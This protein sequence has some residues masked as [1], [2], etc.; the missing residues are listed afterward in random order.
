MAVACPGSAVRSPIDSGHLEQSAV[1]ECFGV[2]MESTNEKY[3]WF[4]LQVKSRREH[5]VCSHL[6]AKGYE[7]FLPQYKCKRRWSDRIKEVVLPLFAGYVFCRFDPENRLPIMVVPGVIVIVGAA[8]K[9]TPVDDSEI[10]V[11]Q[12]IAKSGLPCQPWPFLRV[13][14]RV[15][16]DYGALQGIEGILSSFKSQQRIVVSV[17]LLQRSVALEVD[18][19]W[20]SPVSRQHDVRTNSLFCN[21]RSTPVSPRLGY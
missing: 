16:V 15:R 2:S 7:C 3:P 18:R 1:H 5:I 9:P 8:K 19:A 10:S 20:L 17:T 14:A 21:S 4:A 12:T 11:I 6:Q 13:G